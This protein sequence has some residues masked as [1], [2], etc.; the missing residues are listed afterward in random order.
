MREPIESMDMQELREECKR[1]Q[2]AYNYMRD[3]KN[4]LERRGRDDD[5]ATYRTI[6]LNLSKAVATGKG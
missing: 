6:A 1:L 5:L 4:N 3:E 2:Q